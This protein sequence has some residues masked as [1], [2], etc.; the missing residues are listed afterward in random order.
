MKKVLK[1]TAGLL[2]IISLLISVMVGCSNSNNTENT[3]TET[4]SQGEVKE[5]YEVAVIVKATD[6]DFWQSLLLGANNAMKDNEDK[7]HVTTYGP[8]S[9]ADIDQQVAILENVL[10]KKPDAIVI[11][12][13]SSDATVPMIEEAADAGI[14]VITI[15][16]KVNTDKYTAFLATDNEKGGALAAE[17]MLAEWEARGID[18]SGKK[19]AIISSMA[20]VQVL[21][22]RDSGF[23]KR[24]KELV[25]D[26][27]F[28][29]TRYTDNDIVKALSAAE[30]LLT[31]NK[32]LIGFFAD[33][34]HTGTGASRAVSERGLEDKVMV[35]AFDSDSEEI[36]ALENGSIKAL[37]VQDP[38]GMGYKGTMYAL[39]AI[40]GKDVPKEVDTGATVVIKTN[41]ND[42]SVKKLLDPTLNK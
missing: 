8:P 24:M 17:E 19:V 22:D 16:N 13:T 31:A 1:K 26:I 34:N 12:S 32:D 29:E 2:A 33:N 6:S 23:E 25:P 41:M 7:I 20:G 4:V 40:E 27:K 36:S 5:V 37:V 35:V 18:P 11:A 9:E 14:P 28:I 38:Y 10:A 39:D 21:I 42:E 30:D 3:T 15:D